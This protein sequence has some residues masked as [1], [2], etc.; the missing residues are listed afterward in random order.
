VTT[1]RFTPIEPVTTLNVEPGKKE[2]RKAAGIIGE[3]VLSGSRAARASAAL[4]SWAASG[5]GS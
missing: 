3:V 2:R 4:E 1:P 5:L